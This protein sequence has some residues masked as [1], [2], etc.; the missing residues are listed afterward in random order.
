[1]FSRSSR[2][3]TRGAVAVGLVLGGAFAATDRPATSQAAG[4]VLGQVAPAATPQPPAGF[5]AHDAQV[6]GIRMHYVTGGQGPTLVLLHGYPQT[7]REWFG[8]MPELAKHYTVIAPDLRGAGGSSAPEGGYDKVT[9]AADVHA[10]LVKLGRGDDIDLV[11][12]DIGTMVAYAYAA[13]YRTSVKHLALTEA[14]IPDDTVYTYPSLTEDGPGFWNFG[15]FSLENGLPENTIDGH[16]ETWVAGFMDWLTVNK[17]A[18]TRQDTDAYAAA[19]HDDAHLRASFEW[20]RAFP[21]DNQDVERLGRRK[22]TVPVLAVGAESSLGEAVA[23]QARHY[24]KHVK[25]A[26]IE[27]SGHWIWEEQPAAATSLL[28]DFLDGD[29]PTS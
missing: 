26:V 16:E 2:G 4:Q 19:L 21:A 20:F 9:M 25:K 29:S 22:L 8:V 14:P 23:E 7:S 24:A 5:T 10:L 17:E 6:N 27:D 15:F 13:T 1:M 28:L 11:G 12:H 3:I 18:V